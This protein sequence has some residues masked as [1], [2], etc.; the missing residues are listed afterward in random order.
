MMFRGDLGIINQGYLLTRVGY[1]SLAGLFDGNILVDCHQRFDFDPSGL[2]NIVSCGEERRCRNI[3]EIDTPS[4]KDLDSFSDARVLIT[5]PH[6]DILGFVVWWAQGKG[7]SLL[8]LEEAVDDSG[9][10]LVHCLEITGVCGA[11]IGVLK[12]EEVNKDRPKHIAILGFGNTSKA[13]AS[14][15]YHNGYDFACLS[16]VSGMNSL[17]EGLRSWDMI[18]NGINWPL[19]LRGEEYWLTRDHVSKMKCSSVIIDLDVDL[20][21]MGPIETCGHTSVKEPWY[22]SQGVWH[23][24]I[25]GWPAMDPASAGRQYFPMI[26]NALRAERVPVIVRG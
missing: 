4:H 17:R 13:A 10:R 25:W 6:K 26:G 15:L 12:Y 24:C 3:L 23:S 22:M 9:N 8:A 19:N 14:W 5:M 20:M 2:V 7:V 1:E 16:K 18:I 21:G 11:E